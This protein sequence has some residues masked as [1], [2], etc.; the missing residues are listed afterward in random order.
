MEKITVH[1]EVYHVYQKLR[2]LYIRAES[3]M[4]KPDGLNPLRS[5]LPD[6]E[7]CYKKFL[8]VS[9]TIGD[10]EVIP[11]VEITKQDVVIEKQKFDSQSKSWIADL[12]KTVPV[13]ST[14]SVASSM[15][16]SASS[17]SSRSQKI[18]SQVKLKVA[19]AAMSQETV[20]VHE[21]RL[22]ARQRAE[23]LKR[24]QQEKVELAVRKAREEAELETKKA[25][26]E[27]LETEEAAE[28]EL[29]QKQLEYELAKIEADAWSEVEFQH[30]KKYDF[31]DP[32][33]FRSD[34]QRADNL[35][36]FK[37][38]CPE[39]TSKEYFDQLNSTVMPPLMSEEKQPVY[40]RPSIRRP[41]Q[42]QFT[43]NVKLTSQETG[44]KPVFSSH[45]DGS[46][47]EPRKRKIAIDAHRLT[48]P[49][50]QHMIK[51][52]RLR[53]RDRPVP[54]VQIQKF[55]GMAMHYWVFAR[56]FEAH[57]L[58]KVDECELFPLLYQ[59]CETNVQQKLNHLFNQPPATGF[60]L[61]WDLLYDEYG[62]PHEIARCCEESL[63]SI[64]K[65]LDD[66]REKL[67]S[68]SNLLEKC[69]VSLENIGQVSS[70]DSMHVIMGVV[71]KLP[72]S[73]KRAWVEYSVL[74]ESKT[75]SR[76]RFIDLSEFIS[77][78]SRIANSIFGRETFPSRTESL[79][80]TT[81]LSTIS[82][83]RKIDYRKTATQVSCYYCSKPHKI[84][85][86]S[87]FCEL[88]YDERYKFVRDKG[89]CFKCMTESHSVKDCKSRGKCSVSGCTGNFH[90]TLLHK[91]P[92]VVSR[93]S[94]SDSTQSVQLS[95]SI[96][97]SSVPVYLNVVPVIVKYLGREVAVYAFLDQ[98]SST[99][100]CDQSLVEE[101]QA[102]GQKRKLTLATLSSTKSLD[103]VSISFE[104]ES[105]DGVERIKLSD[106]VVVNSIPVSPNK[107]PTSQTLKRH[108]YLRNIEFPCIEK[109]QVQLLI[110]ANV[111]KVFRVQ[112]IRSA[113]DPSLPDA[114]RSP[115]GWSLL[116]PC[117]D[118]YP[119]ASQESVNFISAKVDDCF[120][121]KIDAIF[122]KSTNKIDGNFVNTLDDSDDQF[123]DKEVSIEDRRV[124][125]LFKSSV[126][127]V[128]GHFELPLPWRHDDQILPN[129]KEMALKRL[130]P[131]EKRFI[132]DKNFKAQYSE[133]IQGMIDKN[134]AEVVDE[135][136]KNFSNRTWFIPH[137]AVVNPKKSKLR[138]VFDCSAEYK[139]LSLNN[140][141][142]QGPD[143]VN[144]LVAV[145]TRFRKDK[146]AIVSDVEAMFYQVSVRPDHR[147]GLQFFWWPNSDIN[148]KP[149]PHR[150]RVHLF[151]ATSSPS[152][153][154]FALRQAAKE[155]GPEFEPY[156]ASAIEES[157]Y[158]DDFLISV[159]NIEIGIEII[160]GVKTL[161]Y[162]AGFRLTKWFSNR[163]EIM[164]A[165]PEAERSQSFMINAIQGNTKERVLGVN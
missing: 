32:V 48:I 25:E 53:G 65:I 81:C 119:V 83:S 146:I 24:E 144:S 164:D 91:P 160:K 124:Y 150:M 62:H 105:L 107:A 49:S 109:R 43:N 93:K 55:D 14:K 140:C 22:R 100:F 128:D 60:Q 143:L 87:Q 36:H 165:I 17:S 154:S 114:V 6:I 56:Q 4:L 89:L 141:L 96:S 54:H 34:K 102:T 136:Q 71:N 88:S 163:Q 45:L 20:K 99:C 137:H 110:G 66:D 30:E 40:S 1:S 138:V 111:P 37:E 90:H 72:I 58:G 113:P 78:K 70:L 97:S 76:A 31:A 50:T 122:L 77:Q 28:K 116:G 63:T 47:H 126:K 33:K 35:V 38:G 106:I 157:F 145:L 152:C 79:R 92:S 86:C 27:L 108:S 3:F 133:Q 13:S 57:V 142:M 158:L 16:S 162:R 155:F 132:R 10:N 15:K 149:I 161:L 67:K 153:A 68:L 118:D 151:G 7:K 85:S 127:F 9:E 2:N 23:Q 21:T 59:N 74:I 8:N 64:S 44:P 139:G 80:K 134:Y 73:L 46:M 19:S 18:M 5:L 95:S 103:T 11:V 121:D 84:S 61:A 112:S 135:T 115:L 94:V 156:I 82:H 129:N 75:G 51:T 29:R 147:N 123:F 125:S 101:L 130:K 120:A 117:L 12:L 131:L 26:Q 104:V 42:Q 39:L 52:S 148:K 98:G 69:C 159:P 41:L